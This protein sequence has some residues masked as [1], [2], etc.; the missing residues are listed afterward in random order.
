MNDADSFTEP[1]TK[2]GKARV[3]EYIKKFNTVEVSN[4]YFTDSTEP[5]RHVRNQNEFIYYACRECTMRGKI[6]VN[7]ID[8][9]DVYQIEVNHIHVPK[10]QRGLSKEVSDKIE[11]YLIQA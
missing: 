7:S 6:E 1:P 8:L 10:P 3:Y 11:K 2:R 5:W 4:K 9:T